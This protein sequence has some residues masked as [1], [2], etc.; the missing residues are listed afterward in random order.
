MAVVRTGAGLSTS[1]LTAETAA[2]LAALDAD[3][4]L[5]RSAPT[6]F[7]PVAQIERRAARRVTPLGFGERSMAIAIALAAA[8]TVTAVAWGWKA[9]AGITPAAWTS[10]VLTFLVG[11]AIVCGSCSFGRQLE[12]SETTVGG[13]AK[14]ESERLQL[15][16]MG[17]LLL[18]V[19][20]IA[21][22]ALAHLAFG[23]SDGSDL[24][25]AQFLAL[26][27]RLRFDWAALITRLN[28]HPAFGHL[29]I[30]VNL[31]APALVAATV[32][33]LGFAN[34][35]RDLAEFLCACSLAISGTLLMLVLR[36]A[37]G[38]YVHLQ[39]DA[40]LFASLNPD[41]GKPLTSMI[42]AWHSGAAAGAGHQ[43]NLLDAQ[44]LLQVPGLMAAVAVLMVYA[45][46][47][48]PW[49]G[50]PGAALSVLMMISAFNENGQYL[51]QQLAGGMLAVGCILFAKALRFKRA[52]KPVVVKIQVD[53]D[54]KFITWSKTE[55]VR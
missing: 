47:R 12:A 15:I 31:I 50:I 53:H 28:R 34:R 11:V 13:F 32:I 5:L 29:L 18:F 1:Q 27:Q 43:I 22:T 40:S 10:V 6:P 42:D 7:V 3:A 39:P 36:P 55:R 14:R 26:D 33:V 21:G 37:A 30:T 52:K 2:M 38:A 23:H 54:A 51:S 41:A 20:G 16:A 9:G 19:L 46:R 4:S 48:L 45:L 35:R 49:V 8:M 24:Q 44:L 17:G 25:D